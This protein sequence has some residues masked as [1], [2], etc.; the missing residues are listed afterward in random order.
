MSTVKQYGI[1]GVG[2]KVQ[3]GK[4]GGHVKYDQTLTDGAA[5]QFRNVQDSALA[6]V[7]AATPLAT[8]DLT[9]KAYVDNLIDTLDKK[10]DGQLQ[11]LNLKQACR[12][13]STQDVPLAGTIPLIIDGK[14]VNNNDRILLKSQTDLTQN[15]LFTMKI[16]GGNYTL[17]RADDANNVTN[18]T[19]GTI[20]NT[21][22]SGGMFT[23][24]TDG[25]EW[26]GT[27]WVLTTPKGIANLGTDALQFTQFSAAGVFVAG[28]GLVKANTTFYANTDGITTYVNST[29]H[30]AVRS[31][32]VAGHVMISNG[33]LSDARW[34]TIDL[35]NTNYIGNSVLAA[36]SGGTGINAYTQGDLI[37]GNTGNTLTKLSIGGQGAV[38][39][40]DGTTPSWLA[41]GS[42]GQFLVMNDDGTTPQWKTIFFDDLRNPTNG[43]LIIDGVDVGTPTNFLQVT[44]AAVGNAI[45]IGSAGETNVDIEVS[46]AGDGLL[47][48]KTGYSFTPASPSNA[49]APKSYV[50]GR[51]DAISTSRIQNTAATTAFDSALSGYDNKATI[52]SQGKVVTEVV[53]SPTAATQGERL[54]IS[55]ADSEIQLQAL[56]NA[57]VGNVNMRFLLQ[58]GGQLFIGTVGDGIVQA[59][60]TYSLKVKGGQGSADVDAGNVYIEAGDST[61]GNHNGGNVI[62]RPGTFTGTGTGGNIQFLDDEQNDLIH[63]NKGAGNAQNYFVLENSAGNIDPTISA[64]KIKAQGASAD[65]S[66]LLDPKGNGLVRVADPTTYYQQLQ[67]AGNVDA[68]VTKQFVMSTV[69]GSTKYAGTGL[70][71]DSGGIFNININANTIKVD[72]SDNVIVNSDNVFGHVLLSSGV[73][74]SEAFWGTIDLTN[75]ATLS[76]ILPTALGGTGNTI[77]AKHD[78][79][80]GTDT[81]SLGKLSVGANNQILGVSNAGILGYSYIGTLR[82]GN[83]KP[84]VSGYG[85]SNAVNWLTTKNAIADGAVEIGTEGDNTN[86]S[87]VLNP[88]GNGLLVAKTGY[89]A[90]IPNN[91]SAETIVTKGYVDQSLLAAASSG[92]RRVVVNSGSHT[93]NIGSV[94]PSIN[95]RSIYVAKVTLNI[96]SPFTGAT[97]ARVY[98]GATE[99]MGFDE[100]DLSVAETFIANTNMMIDGSGAQIKISFYGSDGLTLT[101]PSAGQATIIIDYTIY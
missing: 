48:H 90:S 26:H 72:G 17:E 95:G 67:L 30:I 38:L 73:S 47:V 35:A 69:G 82:D 22:V 44:N 89:T 49:F 93:V 86:I 58:E 92:L 12:L 62:V 3:L 61:T 100:N 43:N 14:T 70:S 21:E 25:E 7:Q 85:V 23:F 40:S 63:F 24:V 18:T 37:V 74:G 54:R 34:G 11:G 77:Y 45:K 97:Y 66:L 84:I 10:F 53:G 33:D 64:L 1:A 96:T 29:N 65:V 32:E 36:T 79:L 41:K 55:H 51:V 56:N 78:L 60:P 91:A 5:F 15:G 4:Q 52:I 28:Q 13:A 59:E 98:G 71:E 99:Y 94:L 81:G 27:G 19:T 39:T 80:V 87:I 57:G 20:T 88:K 9:N 46:P 16:V 83:G 8:A 68:F 75:T 101:A 50:D 31:D 2:Q 76:G 6:R 42:Q